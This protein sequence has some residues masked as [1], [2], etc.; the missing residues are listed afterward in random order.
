MSLRRVLITGSGTVSPFGLGREA[1][2]NG[3]YS[4]SSAVTSLKEQWNDKISDLNCWVGAPLK[5]KLPLKSIGRKFRRTM[6]N[7]AIMGV[8]AAK[9]AIENSAVSD[10]IFQSGRCGVSFSSTTGST[11]SLSSFF[12]EYY[13]KAS[14]KNV[15]SGLFFQVMSH[16]TAANVA[17][18]FNITGRVIS[19]DAACSSSA[20]AIGLGFE[21]IKH[22]IQDVMLCGGSDELDAIV[23]GTFDLLNATSYR[24]NDHP[25]KTPRPF[26]ANRDGTVCGEGAGCLVLEA[27]ESALS[28][29]A[30]ILAEVIGFST[31]SDGSH[32]AQPHSESIVKCIEGA[33]HNAGI[34]PGDVDY[35]NAHATGTLLGDAA[36]AEAINKVFG[37]KAVPV[38]SLKGHMGHTLG[39]SGVLELAASLAMMERGKLVPSLNFEL[40]GEGCREIDCFKSVREGEINIIMK[41]SF[42]FGGI[43]V[44]LILRRYKKDND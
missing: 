40:A 12:K 26:D 1:L 28:R 31:L 24:Y 3:L 19:P 9:E 35:I 4:G 34:A 21:A 8:L 14:L 20:Q 41:N 13:D 25:E 43:N 38:S 22:G 29:E 16:T 10:N 44:V 42:A 15:S 30:P 23:C 17:H 32:L 36:E 37:D 39:A 11:H 27:E 18:A 7:T 2:I 5:E 33:L 6:G